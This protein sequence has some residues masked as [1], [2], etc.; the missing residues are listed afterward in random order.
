M[1]KQ[2][3]DGLE[4]RGEGCVANLTVNGLGDETEMQKR[5]GTDENGG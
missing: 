5:Q 1:K 4:G 2:G 3:A